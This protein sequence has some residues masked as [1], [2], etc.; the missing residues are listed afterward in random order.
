MT[1]LL[2]VTPELVLTE[3]FRRTLTTIYGQGE[4]SRIA[5]D[6]AHCISEWGHD[7]R[8][9]YCHLS[10]FRAAYPMVPIICLTATSTQTVRTDI[11]KTMGLDPSAT[12]VFMASTARRNL[13][14]EIRF[15]S[16]ESDDRFSWLLSWLQKIY[17]RRANDPGRSQEIAS[18]A[19]CNAQRADAI[20]GI[21]YVT[22]R[23]ECD[24]LSS[25]LRSH[26]ISAAPYHAGLSTMERSQCQQKW[27]ENTSGY[28]IIVATTAF[29]MG[30]DKQDV[31]F[32]IHWNLPKSFE[33]Y[34]QEAGRAGRDGWF[35]RC[36]LFYS[37][38][39]RD[40]ANY[41]IAKDAA[42]SGNSNGNGG[43]SAGR[44]KAIQFKSRTQSFQAL[45]KYCEQTNR[46]RH[47]V[48][49]EFFGEDKLEACH[50]GCDFCK[51]AEG[52]KRRKRD[53]LASEEWLST[54]RQREDF[55]GEGYD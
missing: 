40:R 2:Y 32:V 34:Y 14:Y 47:V 17:A 4:L 33:G 10:H 15:T 51:D 28:D 35:A 41:R 27:I 52:L 19:S 20:S 8:P 31:R 29:G 43:G 5:I 13:V 26:N 46:C 42:N 45:V 11:I 53:G 21:I 37:R 16:D 24:S 9:A 55:Y 50:R 25:R 23:S 3:S 12:K 7:F 48:I 38:E 54:Q 39:D 18:E 44:N 49:G 22:F 6:E 30:I 36:L 1:R